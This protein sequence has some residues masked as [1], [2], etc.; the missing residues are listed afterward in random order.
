MKYSIYLVILFF[1][2]PANSFSQTTSSEADSL[3]AIQLQKEMEQSQPVP[4]PTP[5]LRSAVSTNPDIS[6]IADFRGIYN[7]EGK[8]NTD[9][10]FK[11]LEMQI[12]SVVDPF[13]RAD[14]LFSF[15]KDAANEEFGADLETATYTTTSLPWQLQIVLGKFKPHFTKVNQLHPH[16][17]SF[18]EFPMMIK[19]Y[20][21]D[22]G[23]FMEGISGSWLVPNPWD[24][25][26]ELNVEVGRTLSGPTLANGNKNNLLVIAHLKN[27]FDLTDNSTFELGFSGL[28]GPSGPD[29]LDHQVTMAGADFTFKWKPIQF[30]TY[31]SFTWQNEIMTTKAKLADDSNYNSIG[32]YSYMEYQIAKLWFVGAKYDYSNYGLEKDK[33]D[34]A[35]SL[36]LRLQ[37]TEFSIMALEFQNNQK[38]DKINGDSNYNQVTFR[39]IFGIGTHAAHSY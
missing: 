4:P 15:G 22:E 1:A 2:F 38:A 29:S 7:S 5:Q 17:F 28:S 23:L 36:L 19:N 11:Q 34:K 10:Y 30:N 13:G 20:F 3:L 18:V 35:I 6:A 24:F 26:Q 12:S 33:T 39:L 21:G 37:P 8:R 25:Y 32:A 31:Q 14:F 9:L 16:A 27:F